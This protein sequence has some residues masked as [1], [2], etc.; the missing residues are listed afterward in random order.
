MLVYV[1]GRF[2]PRTEAVVSVFDSGFVLGDG[3]WEGIR[4]VHATATGLDPVGH[5]VTLD[6]GNTL[7]YDRLVLSPGVEMQWGALEGYDAAASEQFPV[8]TQKCRKRR[9]SSASS[10]L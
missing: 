4:L 10:K 7:A 9:C 8:K 2:V 5:Q 1:D 6:D 3:I